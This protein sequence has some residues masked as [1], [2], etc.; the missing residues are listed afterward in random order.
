MTAEGGQRGPQEP[1]PA[2]SARFKSLPLDNCIPDLFFL[3]HAS[4]TPRSSPQLGAYFSLDH[5]AAV[6]ATFPVVLVAPSPR[7]HIN[8][9]AS[10]LAHATSSRPAAYING[11]I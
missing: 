3:F 11:P 8:I 10:L 6:A 5:S 9:V 4:P 2:P 1:L 7:S